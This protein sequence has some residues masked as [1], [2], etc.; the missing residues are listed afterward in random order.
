MIIQLKGEFPLILDTNRKQQ[1]N[2]DKRNLKKVISSTFINKEISMIERRFEALDEVNTCNI[3]RNW[4][5]DQTKI[6]FNCK[7]QTMKSPRVN[8]HNRGK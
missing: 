8:L 1:S 6:A 7:T 3:Y 5:I 2:V 4:T